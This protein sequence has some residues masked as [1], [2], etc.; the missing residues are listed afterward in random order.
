MRRIT[1]QFL[2]VNLLG[3]SLTLI[4]VLCLAVSAILYMGRHAYPRLARAA[5]DG[6]YG[7]DVDTLEMQNKAYERIVQTVIPAIVYIRT[8]QVMK[9]DPSPLLMDPFFR[10][11]FGDAL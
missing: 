8:V 10:Q 5:G 1:R 11:F 7:P 2:K 6:L 3:L 4:G 9:V